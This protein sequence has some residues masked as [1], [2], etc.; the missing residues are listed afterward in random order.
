MTIQIPLSSLIEMHVEVEK[1]FSKWD[2]LPHPWT[3]EQFNLR[4]DMMTTKVRLKT[5]VA[6]ATAGQNVE[7][8]E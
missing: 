6:V 7:V 8:V 4:S 2:S 1:L 5:L 3:P